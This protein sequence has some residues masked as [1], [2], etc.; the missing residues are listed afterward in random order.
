M[1]Q[2][3]TA[4]SGGHATDEVE[5]KG[6][7]VGELRHP[8]CTAELQ[9]YSFSSSVSFI[10]HE[11]RS[12]GREGAA[13]ERKSASEMLAMPRK[14]VRAAAVSSFK[15]LLRRWALDRCT[16]ISRQAPLPSLS[17]SLSVKY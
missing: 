17:T 12:R 9:F 3:G 15:R 13:R 11:T 6:G 4:G 8:S 5:R 16:A 10:T 14:R 7:S 1:E 2:G